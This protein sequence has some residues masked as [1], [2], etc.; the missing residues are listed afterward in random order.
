MPLLNGMGEAEQPGVQSLT[1][2]G[3]NPRTYRAC[4]SG[5]PS[6]TCAVDR[7][8]DQRVA[9]MGEM[10][11]DLMGPTRGKTAFNERSMSLER[12]LNL[13]A[14][15]RR[16]PSSFP[17]DGHFFAVYGAATDIASYLASRWGRYPPNKGGIGAIHP[18]CGEITR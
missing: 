1:R 10:N 8:A 16:F 4:A 17:D 3:G 9:E 11:P 7:V 15:D 2:K 6:G 13:V 12:A 5:R 18:A 14:S